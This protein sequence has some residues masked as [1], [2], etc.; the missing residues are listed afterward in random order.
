MGRQRLSKA[1]Q[2][3]LPGSPGDGDAVGGI[4]GEGERAGEQASLLRHAVL[5]APVHG[6][7]EVGVEGA[8]VELNQVEDGGRQALHDPLCR[9]GGTGVRRGGCWPHC[10]RGV[11]LGGGRGAGGTPGMDPG[12]VS[13]GTKW[14]RGRIS[15]FPLC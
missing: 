8:A 11:P 14:A 7:L 15:G 5:P 2:L 12:L 13:P 9:G 4:D 1:R 6:R 3:P 10:L